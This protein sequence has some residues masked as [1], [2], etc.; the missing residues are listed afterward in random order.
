MLLPS[1]VRAFPFS[2]SLLT[3]FGLSAVS[4][5]LF[6]LSLQL[7]PNQLHLEKSC[8]K[9]RNRE[10]MGVSVSQPVPE[11]LRGWLE[12]FWVKEPSLFWDLTPIHVQYSPILTLRGS[13]HFLQSSSPISNS[14][15]TKGCFRQLE[16]LVSQNKT[17]GK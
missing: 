17:S 6:R 16:N 13:E 11:F 12:S 10:H 7:K 14:G 8:L 15:N 5:S 3:P 9:E 4:H 1:L 2:H